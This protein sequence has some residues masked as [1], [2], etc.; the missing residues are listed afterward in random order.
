MW[1]T[2]R[3]ELIKWFQDVVQ[4][5]M[6]KIESGDTTCNPGTTQCRWCL[7]SSRCSAQKDYVLSEAEGAFSDFVEEEQSVFSLDELAELLPKI[8]HIQNWIKAVQGYALRSALAGDKIPGYKLV[9]GRSNRKWGADEKQVVEFL[10]NTAK[11][12]PYTEKLITPPAAEKAIGKKKAADIGLDKYI[13][14]P[15]GKPTLVPVSDTRPEIGEIV[16]E[17]FKEFVTEPPVVKPEAKDIKEEDLT[18]VFFDD[19]LIVD[20][21][22][23]PKEVKK[24]SAWERLQRGLDAE[25]EEKI[26][27]NVMDDVDALN[28]GVNNAKELEDT[29]GEHLTEPSEEKS[30]VLEVTSSSKQTAT[31]G[32]IK[33]KMIGRENAVSPK[34]GTKRLDVLNMGG[35]GVTIKQAAK[36]LGCTENMIN[37]H[38]RYLNEKDGWN[39][40]IYDT[41]EFKVD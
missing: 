30:N 20:K 17:E 38:L 13:T 35:G 15:P 14:K 23:E 39:V 2:T 19:P 40:T 7:N 32:N 27:G 25:L 10:K 9:E 34:T 33:I 36:A 26:N 41:G 1:E 24:L 12:E 22:N 21:P 11:I 5:A 18:G 31:G 6:K 28:I 3:A 37:M 16:E 8:E 29:V 4:P